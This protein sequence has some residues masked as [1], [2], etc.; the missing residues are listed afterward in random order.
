MDRGRHG[1]GMYRTIFQDLII[2]NELDPVEVTTS[3]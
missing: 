2:G 1:A 3:F